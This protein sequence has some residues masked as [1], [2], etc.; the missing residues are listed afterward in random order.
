M[1]L[2]LTIYYLRV[3]LAGQDFKTFPLS[4]IL[5]DP[6]YKDGNTRFTKVPLK[7]FSDQV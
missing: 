1:L 3:I 5:S 7:A 4:V 2:M 6:P